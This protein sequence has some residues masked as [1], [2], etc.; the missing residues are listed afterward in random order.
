MGNTPGL[1]LSFS[2]LNDL[3]L[4]GEQLAVAA[5]ITQLRDFVSSLGLQINMSKYELVAV[6]PE[7]AGI[8]WELFDQNIPW[9]LDGCFKLLGAPICRDRCVLQV[10][11]C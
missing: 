4:A 3:A 2:F 11:Y 6:F 1:D 5:R 10:N 8:N 9:K 7:G